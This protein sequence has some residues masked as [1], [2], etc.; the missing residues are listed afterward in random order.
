MSAVL[1]DWVCGLT[2]MQQS[3]LLTAIRGPDTL[4][5]DHISKLI[6][7]WYRR[8]ILYSAFEHKVLKTPHEEGGGSF[9]GPMPPHLEFN[10]VVTEYLKHVD[11]TPHHFQL[12]LLHASEILG[13]KH[14]VPSIREQWHR[15]YQ[16][17]VSDL[18]LYPET[19]ALMDRRLGDNRANWRERE[20]VLARWSGKEELK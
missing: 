4:P 14:P 12:H 17:L 7:R 18:H 15:T 10:D 11:E 3:V 9:T 5:K 8:C 2:F 20:E 1:Q 19:E 6:L 13:Y 16:R